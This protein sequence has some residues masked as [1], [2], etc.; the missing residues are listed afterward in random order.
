MKNATT[1]D[2]AKHDADLQML[3][4]IANAEHDEAKQRELL[5]E[6]ARSKNKDC[7]DAGEQQLL[8]TMIRDWDHPQFP[9]VVA[10]EWDFGKDLALGPRCVRRPGC[11]DL[12]VASKPVFFG[13]TDGKYYC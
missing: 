3:H 6:H 2:E 10:A 7:P 12:V 13:H 8:E 1:H 11:G 5:I 9:Y 4:D